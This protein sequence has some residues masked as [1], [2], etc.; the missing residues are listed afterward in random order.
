[1][2]EDCESR[3]GISSL[4]FENANFTVCLCEKSCNGVYKRLDL[5]VYVGGGLLIALA[6]LSV[7]L[8]C[9]LICCVRYFTL[10][11]KK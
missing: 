4:L 3:D 10:R 5:L 6:T 11:L 9:C 7:V 8:L 2:I 1:M